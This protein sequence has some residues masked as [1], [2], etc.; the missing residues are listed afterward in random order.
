M[1]LGNDPQRCRHDKVGDKQTGHASNSRT[2]AITWEEV[3]K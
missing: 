1:D 2:H 3:C